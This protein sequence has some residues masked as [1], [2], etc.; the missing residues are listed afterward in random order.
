MRTWG[1]GGLLRRMA[2]ALGRPGAVLYERSGVLHPVWCVEPGWKS[3]ASHLCLCSRQVGRSCSHGE[4]ALTI[5]TITTGFNGHYD[6]TCVICARAG[7][8][9]GSRVHG[10]SFLTAIP[11]DMQPACSCG[12]R[13]RSDCR[14]LPAPTRRRRQWIR[15]AAG[16][17]R[18]A[19]HGD[20]FRCSP[21]LQGGISWD[22][23]L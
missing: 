23:R 13:R 21:G 14:P 15:S 12:C 20:G 22:G 11:C 1:P 3:V 10:A 8:A 7:V 4:L 16:R 9:E 2:A 5:T 6:H 18:S 17:G 19:A